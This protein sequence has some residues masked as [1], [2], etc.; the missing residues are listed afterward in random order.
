MMLDSSYFG[1]VGTLLETQAAWF[2]ALLLVAAA[3]HKLLW[4]ERA[5]AAVSGLTGMLPKA[6]GLA[7]N[8]IAA[9]EMLAAL[10]L[11]VPAYRS[12]GALLAALLWSLYVIAMARAVLTGRRAVDCGCSFGKTHR[13]L[14]RFQLLRTAVLA[15]IALAIAFSPATVTVDAR[16]VSMAVLLLTQGLA[17]CALF[18]LYAALDSIMSLDTLRPGA[19]R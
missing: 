3:A 8:A 1:S 4:R 6:A 18:A 13:P 17:A 14:G 5:S 12:P 19:V 11:L 2:L 7:V 10:G 15:L 9:I 16:G